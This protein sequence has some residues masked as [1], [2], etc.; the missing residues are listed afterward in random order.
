[1]ILVT[2]V[3]WIEKNCKYSDIETYLTITKDLVTTSSWGL[4]H[5]ELKHGRRRLD[6]TIKERLQQQAIQNCRG[7]DRVLYDAELDTPDFY[8]CGTIAGDDWHAHLYGDEDDREILLLNVPIE[9]PEASSLELPFT[10]WVL[11]IKNERKYPPTPD[12]DRFLEN[13]L[14][15]IIEEL[16]SFLQKKLTEL[17]IASLEDYRRV[18]WKGI[19]VNLDGSDKWLDE[20]TRELAY[21]LSIE[22]ILPGDDEEATEKEQ[23]WQSW[24]RRCRKTTLYTQIRLRR[25]VARSKHLFYHQMPRR[26]DGREIILAKKMG[27]VK[28]I[29]RTQHKDAEVFTYVPPRHNSWDNERGFPGVNVL[30]RM[31]KEAGGNVNLDAPGEAERVKRKLG[32]NWRTI[33]GLPEINKTKARPVDWPVHKRFERGRVEP[34]RFKTNSIPADVLRI[35]SDLRKHIENLGLVESKYGVTKDHKCLRGG[36]PLA[37][38]MKSMKEKTVSTKH[39]HL[40]FDEIANTQGQIVVYITDKTEILKLYTSPDAD[41]MVASQGDEA[42]ELLTYLTAKGKQYTIAR[43]PDE[44]NFHE[45]TGL[46]LK[47]IVGTYPSVSDSERAT[48]AYIGSS[49]IKTPQVRTLLLHAIKSTYGAEEAQAYLDKALALD[50]ALTNRSKRMSTPVAH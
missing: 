12:R 6:S 38:F 37:A 26:E 19:Y 30:L 50:S 36:Q 2:L 49:I 42:F 1:M 11:N 29:L 39:G 27:V 34:K 18:R 35:P 43:H 33:C 8:F 10:A 14:K 32:R 20:R 15:P 40:T 46:E 13:A 5:T 9:A 47:E 3:E 17:N 22:V 31:L 41:A 44:K 21:L 28:A 7:K 48:I 25:L 23:R 16:Q 4:K 45:R 24:H